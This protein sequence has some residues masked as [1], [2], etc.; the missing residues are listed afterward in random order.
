VLDI[1]ALHH[2]RPAVAS[3]LLLV[4]LPALAGAAPFAWSVPSGIETWSTGHV[5]TVLWSGGPASPVNIHLIQLPANVIAQTVVLG[6]VND[7]ERVF[8]L[9]ASLAPGTY[10][11]YIEDTAQ[12]EWAYGPQ[13]HVA[14][15]EPCVAPC[16]GG[17]LG[18]PALVCGQTQAE[19][20]ALAIAL[21]QSQI[22][23]GMAGSVD[24]NS[25]EIETTLL[26]V[27]AYPCPAGY[28][29]AYAVEAS[30]VWCCCLPP[31]GTQDTPWT[32]VKSLYRD[33]RD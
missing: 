18:A 4:A 12:T 11:M 24:P 26:A 33:R 7:G 30:A 27:G 15:T 3:G 29:G 1:R 23:C 31:V 17:A 8:R 2:V 9:S 14:V 19:A 5:H 25:I 20:E 6:D 10:Q 32:G 13:F 21:A 16:T 22:G 28:G